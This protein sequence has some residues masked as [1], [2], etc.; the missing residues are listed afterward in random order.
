MEQV[1]GI[2]ANWQNKDRRN[3]RR[4]NQDNKTRR[5]RD[6]MNPKRLNKINQMVPPSIKKENFQVTG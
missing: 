5:L 3:R 4:N 2:L 1:E 6:K